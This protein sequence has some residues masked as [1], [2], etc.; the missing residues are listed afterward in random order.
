M[1]VHIYY[2]HVYIYI[3]ISMLY[4][5]NIR[6]FPQVPLLFIN[7]YACIY[8]CVYIFIHIYIYSGQRLH[9]SRSYPQVR[10]LLSAFKQREKSLAF[11]TIYFFQFFKMRVC[12]CI[13]DY[14]YI[15]IYIYIFTCIIGNYLFSFF[16]NQVRFLLSAFKQRGKSLAFLPQTVHTLR[17]RLSVRHK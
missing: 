13:Y 16:S 3:Y 2:I 11:L 10:F 4:L 14:I 6:F 15:Y 7:L 8:M 12:M 1:Y 9:S 17:S 5:I